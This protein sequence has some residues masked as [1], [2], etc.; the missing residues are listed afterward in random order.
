[1]LLLIHSVYIYVYIYVWVYI[2]HLVT[3]E[4]TNDFH[5]SVL[6]HAVRLILVIYNSLYRDFTITVTA[7]SEA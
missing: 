6:I 2:L 3:I 5:E 4:R 7:R 1:M